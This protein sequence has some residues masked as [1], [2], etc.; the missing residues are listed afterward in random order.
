MA[1]PLTWLSGKTE[2]R[3]S[4]I[5]G[6]GLFARV[7]LDADETVAVKGEYVLTHEQRDRLA[8]VMRDAE[9]QIADDLFLG[10]LTPHEREAA[11]MFPNASGP[12]CRLV[13]GLS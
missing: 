4:A 7:K 3:D 10:P 1:P 12:L 2:I 9:I 5:E 11:M 8:S 6:H 13:L